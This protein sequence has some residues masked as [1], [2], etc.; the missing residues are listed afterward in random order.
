[1]A[2]CA[3]FT[4]FSSLMYDC[5]HWLKSLV[6]YCSKWY[7]D[8]CVTVSE[9][10]HK[11]KYVLFFW[12]SVLLYNPFLCFWFKSPNHTFTSVRMKFSLWKIFSVQIS[13]VFLSLDILS[14]LSFV[15]CTQF[16][17]FFLNKLSDD[18]MTAPKWQ[19]GGILKF[20][21]SRNRS[22]L[23]IEGLHRNFS[24]SSVL[25]MCKITVRESWVLAGIM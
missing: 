3:H 19:Q 22:S 20:I 12:L 17:I 11:C 16:V 13:H 8:K 9:K 24:G 15:T 7:N 5:A 4:F 1:M 6:F 10:W 25:M 18:E 23:I 21:I 14:S 2:G